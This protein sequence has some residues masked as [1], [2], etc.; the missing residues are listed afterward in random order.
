MSS[1]NIL[2]Y[3][4]NCELS[5][6]LILLLNNEKLNR[7]FHSVCV[8][9][10]P[11]IPP[12]IKFTPTLIIRGVPTPYVAGDAFAW[13]SKVKQWK[14]NMTMQR[15]STAQQQYLNNINSNLVANQSNVLGFSQ[16][17]MEGMSDIFAYLQDDNAM[18]H[19]YF[20]CNNLG[21]ENIMTPPLEDGQ[22]KI[23]TDGKY[24]INSTKS[25]ELHNALEMERRKQDEVF[26][27]HIEDFKKQYVSK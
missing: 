4:N 16:A 24:K 15:M 17:E 27:Q 3:S 12:Q 19:S 21:K 13:F 18:P 14:I 1:V 8:D 5:Q 11:K 25:K 6:Q 7:F 23:N 2:F 9:N 10:N 22:Y 20:T 26:K